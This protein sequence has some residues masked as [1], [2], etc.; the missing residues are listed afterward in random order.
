MLR[1]DKVIGFVLSQFVGKLIRGW[2]DDIFHKFSYLPSLFKVAL[3]LK[4][5]KLTPSQFN[6]LLLWLLRVGI[7]ED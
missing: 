3:A 2:L 4:W 7:L 6:Y 1:T 5:E